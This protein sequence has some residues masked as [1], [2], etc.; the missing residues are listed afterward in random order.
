[1]SPCYTLCRLF[2]IAS[3]LASCTPQNNHTPIT[4]YSVDGVQDA[5]KLMADCH[6]YA[7]CLMIRHDRDDTEGFRLARLIKF[8]RFE[9]KRH[10]SI[11]EAY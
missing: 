7:S 6:A 1:M 8:A 11:L 10:E 4:R 2:D 3:S 5:V 9:K